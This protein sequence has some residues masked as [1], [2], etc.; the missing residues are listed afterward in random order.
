MRRRRYYLE[1]AIAEARRIRR[2]LL[3][4]R[5]WKIMDLAGACGLASVMLSIAVNDVSILRYGEAKLYGE[6]H[7]WAVVGRTIIDI[8]ASQFNQPDEEEDNIRGVLIDETPRRF[9]PSALKSG[10]DVYLMIVNGRWY[11]EKDH[12]DWGWISEYW[13]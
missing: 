5:S 2:N 1:D 4:M 11:T 6:G 10:I 8:T 9:H 3:R 13:L 12:P 7:V